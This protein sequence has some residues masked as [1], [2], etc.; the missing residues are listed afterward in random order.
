MKNRKIRTAAKRA[1]VVTAAAAA[2]LAAGTL[3]AAPASADSSTGKY[4]T[5]EHTE[6]NTTRVFTVTSSTPGSAVSLSTYTGSARQHW[7]WEPANGLGM[8]L[9][10]SSTDLCL[11]A[12]FPSGPLTQKNCAEVSGQLWLWRYPIGGTSRLIN[13]PTN[14]VLGDPAVTASFTSLR[15]G[16]QYTFEHPSQIFKQKFRGQA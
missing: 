3:A 2:T 8:H 11:N 1:V 15:L 12:D 9:V 16:P 10:N 5:I 4:Y 6:L 14:N 13:K 7:H